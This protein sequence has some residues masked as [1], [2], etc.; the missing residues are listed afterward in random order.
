MTPCWLRR[1][2]VC[3]W[4]GAACLLAGC[5]PGEVRGARLKGQVLQNGQPLKP[6]P[7]ERVWVTFERIEPPADKQVIMS[8]GPLQKDGT[9]TIEGQVKKGTPPGKYAVT[10]HGEFSS[11]ERENRFGPLFPEGKSPF[12]AEVTDQEDQSFVLDVGKRTIT[13]Q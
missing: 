1:A 2:A 11:G 9:F 12:L 8:A 5:G 6:L 7:G 4:I 13:K 3:S 10:L